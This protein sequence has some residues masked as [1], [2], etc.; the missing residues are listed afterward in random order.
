MLYGVSIMLR[1]IPVMHSAER[2]TLKLEGNVDTRC[3]DLLER[4]CAPLLAAAASLTIDMTAV[5]YVDQA[6]TE[7]LRRL[8]RAGAQIRCRSGV[9]ASVLESEG[10]KITLVSSS[11]G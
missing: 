6:G 8:H 5:W 10:L 9:I 11:E 4:E 3:V 1:I 2:V 7:V